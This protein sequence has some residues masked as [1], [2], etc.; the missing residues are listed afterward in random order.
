LEL[1]EKLNNKT[2]IKNALIMI[3]A[4]L[5]MVSCDFTNERGKLRE[6]N[7]SLQAELM[8]TMRAVEAMEEVGVLMD[9]IDRNRNAIRLDMTEGLQYDE[10]VKRME[11]LNSYVKQS[12]DRLAE[13]EAELEKSEGSKNAYARAI[14]RLKNEIQQKNKDI[15]EL[16]ELVEQYKTENMELVS[17]VALRESEL[18]DAEVDIMKKKQELTLLETRIQEIMIQSKMTEA[19]AYFA[20]AAAVEEAANRTKLAPGKKKDTYREA[21]ELYKKALELGREDARPKINELNTKIN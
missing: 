12:E 15:L 11:S 17:L 6:A 19:D 18:A 20:R 4:T 13:L 9:S 3:F 5:V 1:K 8:V 21:I 7:D 14:S 2:M 16:Q 10:Y